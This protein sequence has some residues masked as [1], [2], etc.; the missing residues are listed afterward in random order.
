M[1]REGRGTGKIDRPGVTMK[2]NVWEKSY[3]RLGFVFVKQRD[4]G[5]RRLAWV[6]YVCPLNGVVRRTAG[7][8]SP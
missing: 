6:G 3:T 7:E 8:L 4:V 5:L 1:A 2:E